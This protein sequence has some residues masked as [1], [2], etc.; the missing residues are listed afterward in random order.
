MRRAALEFDREWDVIAYSGLPRRAPSIALHD[1]VQEFR[2][3]F[4]AGNQQMIPG[5]GAGDV[6]QSRGWAFSMPAGSVACGQAS[7]APQNTSPSIAG[8]MVR[9]HLPPAPSPVRT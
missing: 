9:I 6:E 4:D 3:R 2:Y 1:V 8:P 5:A 7:G